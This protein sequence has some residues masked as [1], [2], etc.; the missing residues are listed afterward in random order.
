MPSSMLDRLDFLYSVDHLYR[1]IHN[2]QVFMHSAQ[3]HVYSAYDGTKSAG[4][5]EG[6][7]LPNCC[8]LIK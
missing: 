4:T 3:T 7:V 6:G 8:N 2:H 1:Q 5:S